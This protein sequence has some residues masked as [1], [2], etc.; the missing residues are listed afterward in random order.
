MDDADEI[1]RATTTGPEAHRVEGRPRGDR[2]AEAET[3]RHIREAKSDPAMRS[4]SR[5][6]AESGDL[7]AEPARFPV[8]KHELRWR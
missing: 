5:R 8:R 2:A 3:Q 1:V 6:R 4:P 7:P